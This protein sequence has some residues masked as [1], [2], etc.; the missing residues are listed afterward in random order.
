[1]HKDGL[2]AK[3]ACDGAG[4][5]APGTTKAGQH[6]LS[7]VVALALGGGGLSLI[8]GVC[9]IRGASLIEGRA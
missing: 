6:V 2:H 4:V 5:L 7:R 9:L 8:R 3:A 1:M